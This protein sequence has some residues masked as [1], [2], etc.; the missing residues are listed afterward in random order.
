MLAEL[1]LTARN[2]VLVSGVGLGLSIAYYLIQYARHERRIQ[3]IG[4][5]R[6]PRLAVNVFRGEILRH[7]PIDS[8]LRL[9]VSPSLSL[10]LV[11][12]I[13]TTAYSLPLF[14]SAKQAR[15]G[16]PSA[17]RRRRHTRSSTTSTRP[18]RGPARRAART[19]SRSR[20]SRRSGT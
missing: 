5:V 15:Y 1:A 7:S 11:L 12:S 16:S 18:S 14:F 8:F 3:K 13:I 2:A 6:A 17:S 4:G 10:S 20:S 9:S 19:A